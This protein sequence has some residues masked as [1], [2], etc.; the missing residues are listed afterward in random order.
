MRKRMLFLAT[1]ALVA[2]GAV[3]AISAPGP[4]GHH[5]EMW[6]QHDEMGGGP[7]GR[8]RW[9][10][11]R[12][13]T[14]DEYDTRTREQFARLD[15]NGDGVLDANEIQ[16]GASQRRVRHRGPE[17]REAG[18]GNLTEGYIRRFGDKDGKVTKDAMLTEAKRQF[19]QLDLDNDGKITDSDLPPVMRGRGMLKANGP[20]VPGPMGRMVTALRE[21][22]VKGDG[23]ITQEAYLAQRTKRFDEL[24]R[25]NDGV[26][27]KA[28]AD[29]LRKEMSDYQ[30]KRFLHMYGAGTQGTITK[31]QFYKVA[32]ERFARLDRKGEG[33]ITFERPEGGQRGG[34]FA[35]RDRPER[36]DRQDDGNDRRRESGP[37]SQPKN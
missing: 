2:V 35:K 13:I 21:A 10:G 23:I 12:S 17:S 3:A 29:L 7:P 31:D 25:N 26:V 19:A 15:K 6:G 33:K 32:K 28:D 14:A 4:R 30:T 20:A 9:L 37:Q 36:P 11:P 5:G 27:D 1:G 8:R 34:W 18:P 22:D 16:A 24:D